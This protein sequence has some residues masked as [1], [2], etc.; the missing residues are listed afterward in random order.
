MH[1]IIL[2]AAGYSLLLSSL[3]T[4]IVLI[5]KGLRQYKR[6]PM[7]VLSTS[8]V[9]SSMFTAILLLLNQLKVLN[10]IP[11][12][13]EVN[14]TN[15]NRTL[16]LRMTNEERY[17]EAF[18]QFHKIYNSNQ[19][20]GGNFNSSASSTC[21][22]NHVIMHYAMFLVPFANAFLSLLSFFMHS[23]WDITCTDN[24]CLQLMELQQ[25][26]KNNTKQDRRL[27][28]DSVTRENI[29]STVLNVCNETKITKLKNDKGSLTS[30][31]VIS[32]WIVPVLL[33]AILHFSKI[34]D[35][36]SVRDAKDTECVFTV[37]F[38][39]EN[40]YAITDPMEFE[41]LS[42]EEHSTPAD[43]DYIGSDETL[44]LSN[45]DTKET[46]AVVSSVYKLIQSLINETED[47]FTSEKSSGYYDT[48]ELWNVTKYFDKDKVE[49][50]VQSQRYTVVKN[51]TSPS[52]TSILRG[53]ES[54]TETSEDDITLATITDSDVEKEK[55]EVEL[56]EDAMRE[57]NAKINAETSTQIAVVQEFQENIIVKKE[58]VDAVN[59]GS[60][61]TTER[62]L[63][64]QQ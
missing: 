62:T 49:K 27:S 6:T 59:S 22:F 18:Q 16:L 31:S 60:L 11:Y 25:K 21:T 38:P 26:N 14:D 58:N 13:S 19:S 3:V 33:T 30:L 54:V 17:Q 52:D 35:M 43:N 63:R 39:F 4:L 2:G 10:G 42:L 48:S 47:N 40:C 51:D 46:D 12:S 7:Y 28:R 37:N 9:L 8:D 57:A 29:R 23:N 34:Q 61:S 20:D 55:V 50:G 44:R 36:S 45:P 1:S 15:D 56:F 41:S 32:Q 24:R 5:R 64:W 53:N